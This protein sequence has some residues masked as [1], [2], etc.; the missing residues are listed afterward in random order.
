MAYGLCSTFGENDL[1]CHW[2]G[3]GGPHV[4]AGRKLDTSDYVVIKTERLI[5]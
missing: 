2:V 1:A 3:L 5:K 4:T